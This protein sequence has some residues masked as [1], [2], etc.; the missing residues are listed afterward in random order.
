MLYEEA[1]FNSTF[2]SILV[3]ILEVGCLNITTSEVVDTNIGIKIEIAIT[4]PVIIEPVEIKYIDKEIEVG[5][6]R[7]VCIEIGGKVLCR[8]GR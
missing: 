7:I 2:N 6:T 4:K 1:V 8:S 5:N 3:T